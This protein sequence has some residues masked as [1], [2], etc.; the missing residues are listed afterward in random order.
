MENEISR[1]NEVTYKFNALDIRKLVEQNPDYF[2]IKTS[3]EPRQINDE[4]LGVVVIVA[5]AYTAGK[6]LVGTTSG[7]PVPPCTTP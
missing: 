5:E 2:L 1:P 4:Q 7:C 3:I 6:A